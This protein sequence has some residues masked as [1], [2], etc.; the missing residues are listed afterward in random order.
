M[1]P[2]PIAFI[3]ARLVDPLAERMI[4]GGVLD[5]LI[6]GLGLSVTARV[7]K[8][9]ALERRRRTLVWGAFRM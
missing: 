6:A 9:R 1:P 4:H 8:L 5:G 2:R 7:H 3:N